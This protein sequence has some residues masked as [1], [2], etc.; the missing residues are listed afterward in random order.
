MTPKENQRIFRIFFRLALLFPVLAVLACSEQSPGAKSDCRPTPYDEIGPFYRP[1]AP[2]RE[3]V[4]EGYLLTGT[5]LSAS[6]CRPLAGARIEFW[7]VNPQGQYSE[8]HRATVYAG[9]LGGYRFQSNR[10][11]EYVGRRPHIHIMVTAEGHAQL[12]TQHYPEMNA[13]EAVFDL[14]LER[15]VAR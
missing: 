15:A 9:P 1:N 13:A 6:D 5:V 2:V 10:P 7:L 3:A 12:I 8:T 14:V 11:T 4:G